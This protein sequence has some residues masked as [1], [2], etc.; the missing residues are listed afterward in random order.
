MILFIC[1]I[2]DFR[3]TL[4]LMRGTHKSRRIQYFLDTCDFTLTNGYVQLAIP[5]AVFVRKCKT[6]GTE[7]A[8]M[9]DLNKLVFDRLCVKLN[10]DEKN[11]SQLF[12]SDFDII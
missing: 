12:S 4:T 11:I 2:K 8:S 9:A 6:I 3:N 1:N 7:K 5:G 10:L